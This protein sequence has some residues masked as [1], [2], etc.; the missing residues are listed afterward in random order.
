MQRISKIIIENFKFFYGQVTFDL[1]RKNLLLFG[2]NGSGKSSLYWSLFTF[3]QSVF[4]AND[5]DIKKYFD[6][7]DELNL[8][9]R[10]HLG[11]ESSIKVEFEEDDAT[12]I[13]KQISFNTINTKS[14]NLVLET[15]R[16]SDFINYKLLSSIYN[17]SH[18][19]SIDL[20]PIF[21][22][23]LLVFITF[24]GNRNAHDLWQIISAGL[25]PRPR[26]HDQPY[27]DYQQRISEFNRDLQTYLNGIIETANEYL[28]QKFKE[29]LK[30]KLKYVPCSY[31][32]F[33]R[34]STTKRNH[35][36]K[37]PEI[38]LSVDFAHD[39]LANGRED[40]KTP[41]SFLNEAKLTSIALAIRFAILDEKYIDGAP[42]V[43]VLDDLLISLDMSNRD[44][45]LDLILREFEDYQIMMMTHDRLFFEIAKHKIK[46][47]GNEQWKFI[48]MY[49]AVKNDIPQPFIT[50]SETYLEKAKKYFNKKEYE[51]AGNFLRKEAESFC[52][53]FL[54]KRRQFT[55]DYTLYDLNGL[56]NQSIL[57][58]KDL[59]LNDPLF[60]E[61]DGHRKFV[62]NPVSHD[63]YDV[64]KYNSEIEKCI[65]TLD[66][67]RAIEVEIVVFK[68]DEIE[69][70]LT[71]NGTTD[72]YKFN[73]TVQED[74]K[75]IKEPGKDSV[76]GRGN[77]NYTVFKNGSPT[78]TYLQHSIESL[79]SFYDKNYEKSD[80]AKS[81]DFWNE[82]IFS[83]NSVP[84]A[85]RRKF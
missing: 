32:D 1:E 2:E 69:F 80:K 5:D 14:G 58:A 35:K 6:P 79:N 56:I 52:K 16:T 53:E 47:L 49:E 25:N 62:L 26:M 60:E 84:L 57:V 34:H 48:E 67:L 81:A 65:D 9:N 27:R 78:T 15:T 76:L 59:G 10:F 70:S 74:L 85:T 21:R 44:N 13:T 24:P 38:I 12:T 4:K 8:I 73:I 39:L 22:N 82:I 36:L 31:D 72:V 71:L 33:V 3:L 11:Q 83:L 7:T 54:P 29:K 77:I 28:E 20:F 41:H 66:N 55:P 75:L 18:S 40:I 17:Y 23:D 46:K 43:L 51:I 30:L 63:S 42:K 61:L 68:G 37:N 19:D 64:P 45:V 50:Y